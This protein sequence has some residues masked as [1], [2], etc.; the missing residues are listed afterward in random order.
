MVKNMIIGILVVII[1]F[2]C[3]VSLNILGLKDR[4]DPVIGVL[5]ERFTSLG[6]SKT[7]VQ[8]S[9]SVQPEE[10]ITQLMENI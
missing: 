8:A 4:V 10:L 6:A 7:A 9:G 1:L 5:G 2:F 3:A